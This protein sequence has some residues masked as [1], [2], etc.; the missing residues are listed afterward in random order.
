MK[1]YSKINFRIPFLFVSIF[2]LHTI[3]GCT[4]SDNNDLD[5]PEKELKSVE[6]T[7]SDAETF[8]TIDGF[9]FFGAHDVWWGDESNLWNEKWGEKV[10]RDLGITIWR[11][12]IYPPS[13]AEVSQDADW[14]KQQ[15][16]VAGLK[17]VADQNNVDLKFIASVWSPPA[18]LKWECEFEWAGDEN[19]QR[20]PGD[21]S[22]K[23]GGTLSPGK[24][25]EFA[26]W[27]NLNINQ[28]AD[29]GVDLYA[30]S[31]QNEPLFKQSFNSCTYT[32]FWYNDLLKN[33]VSEIKADY[34]EIRI[35]GSENMLEMEGK[36]NNWQWFYHNAIK[37]DANV[38]E[39]LDILAVHGYSNGVAPS[40]GSILAQMWMNHLNQFALPMNK[41]VWMTETS[42]YNDTWNKN[43]DKPG[44]F[45]LAMDIMAALNYGNISA[46]L[47]WQGSELK[48]IGEFSLMEGTKAGKKYF[49]SKH[50]YRYIRPGAVRINA[51]TNDEDIFVSAFKHENKGTQTVVI[52]NAGE[53]AKRIM[54]NGDNMPEK[55]NMYR[56][57]AVSENCDL[58]KEI[59]PYAE[60]GF[61]LPAG[62]IVTLQAG[63]DE[64]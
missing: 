53:E 56:T 34:P 54:L 46:W 44:A 2:F 45:N 41:K 62:S 59:D 14:G 35:F 1:Y 8:Q 20:Y 4:Q 22:T 24:Y 32:T 26:D 9:G 27:L 31:L 60:N 16:V 42:G 36:D 43:A 17:T 12:E 49:V 64:L 19:A 23:N 11:N 10:I 30:L 5:I 21:V 29:I 13:T 39:N 48:G 51:T 6:I 38:S 47:W 7:I 58:I 55:F 40:S 15:P 52:I 63:G 18:D 50:Y 28:Y 61:E 33:V 3:W 37:S 25:S 57:N